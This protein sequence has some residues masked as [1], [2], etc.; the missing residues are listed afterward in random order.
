M[1]FWEIVR[2]LAL[3]V[4]TVALLFGSA[5]AA[6]L[7]EGLKHLES[8]D[9]AS[10]FITVSDK[11]LADSDNLSTGFDP[12][13]AGDNRVALAIA[14]I[15]NEG[16]VRN[17]DVGSAQTV[18]DALNTMIG[19]IGVQARHERQMF[20]HQ[21]AIMEQLET[22]R[23]SVSGVSLEEEAINMMKHQTV[24]NAAAKA[25]KIGDELFQTI[26]SIK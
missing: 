15:Q 5:R 24:F 12:T 3:R 25:L 9:G 22:H 23:Q 21:D 16:L 10:Y 20:E 2:S 7:E 11:L 13:A 17:G 1:S 26:L 6:T 8:A 19:H 18:N 14:D 4:L